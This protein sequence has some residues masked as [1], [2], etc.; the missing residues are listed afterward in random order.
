VDPALSPPFERRQ[1]ARRTSVD[2]HFVLSARVKLGNEALVVD[3]SAGGALVDTQ[4]RVLPGATVEL[5]L[6]T[7]THVCAARG[8]IL[9]CAVV[10]VGAQSVWYRAAIGFDRA[11]PWLAARDAGGY[12]VPDDDLRPARDGRVDVTRDVC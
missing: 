2:E 1:S 8:R 10:R 4:S 9:R 11:L 7:Q 5:L 6:N 3:I 12:R